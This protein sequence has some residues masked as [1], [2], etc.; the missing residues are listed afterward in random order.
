MIT[1][2]PAAIIRAAMVGCLIG[3]AYLLGTVAYGIALHG[4]CI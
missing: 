2:I 3:A 4:L 1:G